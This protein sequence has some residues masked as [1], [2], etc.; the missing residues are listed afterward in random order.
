MKLV[1][2]R[3][4]LNFHEKKI[5]HFC[6]KHII[7][8]NPQ[9]ISIYETCNNTCK[10]IVTGDSRW[11]IS[12]THCFRQL[13]QEVKVISRHL[14]LSCCSQVF[15]VQQAGKPL[16]QTE[17]MESCQVGFVR[18]EDLCFGHYTRSQLVLRNAIEHQRSKL[19]PLI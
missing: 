16:N 19:C 2:Q 10:L 18:N 1:S 12:V 7:Y 4:N 8:E 6:N 3:F 9:T 17:D 13:K 15:W 11:A 14:L 5:R